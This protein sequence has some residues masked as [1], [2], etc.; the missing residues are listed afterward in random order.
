MAKTSQG[1]TAT[2]GA[3][4]FA[5]VVN[6]SVDGVQTGT[7]EIVPRTT[8]RAVKYSPTDVDYGTVTLVA[9]DATGMVTGNVGTT[10][11][12]SISGPSAS[13]SFPTAI[14]ERLNWQAATGELQTYS[15]TF[16]IGG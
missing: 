13:W 16:K 5:E 8:T 9:R 14:Y 15:V 11:A 2:W 10:A 1:T 3:T 7:V 6:V 4:T 12:L